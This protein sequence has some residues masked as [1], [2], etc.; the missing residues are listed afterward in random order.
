MFNYLLSLQTL[1]ILIAG[2]CPAL[3]IDHRL[4][5][6][7]SIDA[8]LPRRRRRCRAGG[9]VLSLASRHP[10]ASTRQQCK[11]MRLIGVG[12]QEVVASVFITAHQI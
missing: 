4:F 11:C 9:A 3:E 1:F 6:S 5:L 7:G 8:A 12:D 10:Q 2:T